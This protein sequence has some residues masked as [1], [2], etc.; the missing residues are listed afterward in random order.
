MNKVVC[1]T[2][3]PNHPLEILKDDLLKAIGEYEIADVTESNAKRQDLVSLDQNPIKSNATTENS[4]STIRPR[5]LTG[6]RPTG[7]LHLGHYVG[8][9]AN[10]VK[11][12]DEYEE[13]IMI[14][15]V[16]ALTDNYDNPQKVRDNVLE[17]AMDYL[18]VGIDPLKTTIFIQSQ[19]PEIAELT[20]FF[21][22]LVT[23]AQVLRNPTVKTEIIEKGFADSTPFG[24]VAYPVSQ[25]ADILFL[26]ASLVPVGNDQAPMLELADEIGQ[27]FNKIGVGSDSIK[28][29]WGVGYKLY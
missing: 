9:L 18:A 14:A 6:D 26:K 21:M 1:G 16:Q 12:Q 28:T 11:L 29:I 13:F 25:A 17:V 24:F 19:I 4:K 23:H 10:R 27:R 22:N 2:T 20:I 15:D 3:S 8:S 5:I 7:K